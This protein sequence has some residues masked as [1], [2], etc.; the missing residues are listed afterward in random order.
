M[1]A[2]ISLRKDINELIYKTE[3]NSESKNKVMVTKGKREWRR[4]KLAIW[5]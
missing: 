2:L 4:D 3:T 5:N 1:I